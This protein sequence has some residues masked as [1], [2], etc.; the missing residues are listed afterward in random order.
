MKE[1]TFEELKEIEKEIL[2]Q[3]DS[4]CCENSLRYSLGGGTLLGAVRHNGFIPWDD[5]VDVMMPRP[6]YDRFL[7]M[8]KEKEPPFDVISHD[9]DS[10]YYH[11]FS[12]AQA[13]NTY[14]DNGSNNKRYGINIDVFPIDG[15]GGDQH[16]A[17]KNFNR[18]SFLR[19]LLIAKKWARF[20]RS[21]THSMIYE[22][23][24]LV[25]F[26]ISRFASADK[27]IRKIEKIMRSIDFE[28]SEYAGCVCGSYRT[29]EIIPAEH[30]KHYKGILFEG[31]EL[32]CI[33]DYDQYLRQHYG[34][35]MKLPPKEKQVT[36]H[37]FKAYILDEEG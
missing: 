18:S 17:V 1:V 2:F 6:D 26:L 37:T 24:R 7:S 27:L 5:D 23:I 14:T 10:D 25:L 19:E 9:S 35:Y 21:K 11:L 28:S 31:R 15:L 36:H 30:F 13:R 12:K 20:S 34:D 8:C 16:Q 32:Q 33:R 29:A 3:F 4:Y 22:P